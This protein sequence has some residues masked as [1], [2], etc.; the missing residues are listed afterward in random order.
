MEHDSLLF[1]VHSA[2]VFYCLDA[3]DGSLI[4]RHETPGKIQSRT[5]IMKDTMHVE[6]GVDYQ[7]LARRNGEPVS[8]SI[9][10]GENWPTLV[11]AVSP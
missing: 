1:V 11:N 3:E 5:L 6:P 4:W 7:V 8:S 2:G 10:C 9:E